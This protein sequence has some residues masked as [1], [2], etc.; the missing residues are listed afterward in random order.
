MAKQQ[1]QEKLA[2]I[3]AQSPRNGNVISKEETEKF[4]ED[5]GL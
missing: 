2:G 4:F 1:F 5:E 3:L